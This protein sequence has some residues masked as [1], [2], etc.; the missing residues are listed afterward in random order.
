[1]NAIQIDSWLLQESYFPS[2]ELRYVDSSYSNPVHYP[3]EYIDAEHQRSY[4][5]AFLTVLRLTS[6]LLGVS[7]FWAYRSKQKTRQFFE[8]TE[9]ARKNLIQKHSLYKNALSK[10]L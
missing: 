2:R 1:M 7:I 4:M 8:L 5:W 6:A 3:E 10:V 9:K